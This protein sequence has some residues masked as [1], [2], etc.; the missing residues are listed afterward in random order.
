MADMRLLTLIEAARVLDVAPAT[1]RA[2][3]HREKLRATKRG[4]DWM[5]DEDE[6]ARYR[7]ESQAKRKG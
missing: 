4:R 6:V 2:Q 7:R 3:I 5:V 1:L